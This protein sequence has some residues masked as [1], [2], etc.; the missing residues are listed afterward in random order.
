MNSIRLVRAIGPQA[1][2]VGA[3]PTMARRS[4]GA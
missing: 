2:R 4:D 1:A 3:R